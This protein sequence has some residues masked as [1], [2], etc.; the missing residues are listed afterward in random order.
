MP[1]ISE[2]T[3]RLMAMRDSVDEKFVAYAR[4][5]TL[6]GNYESLAYLALTGGRLDAIIRRN[7][8]HERKTRRP[9]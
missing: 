4:P 3:L 7:L 1:K 2:G 9:E 5:E 8:A 6:S